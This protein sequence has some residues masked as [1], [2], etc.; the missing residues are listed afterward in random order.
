M[1]AVREFTSA[2][3]MKAHAASLKAKFFKPQP[4]KPQNSL[5][6][7][8]NAN[9]PKPLPKLIRFVEREPREWQTKTIDFN[10]HI[11]AYRLHQI[12]IEMEIVEGEVSFSLH[13]KSVTSI[14]DEVLNQFPGVTLSELRGVCRSLPIVKVRHLAMYEVWR[15]RPDLS[16]PAL[17]SWFGN[18]DHATVINAVRKICAEKGVDMP[19]RKPGVAG[20]PLPLKS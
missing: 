5:L 10:S 7:A 2:A 20:Q 13:R 4:V 15:Q 8:S 1:I 19:P 16:W 17:G 18:R 3:E 12:R 6:A 11:V 9:T 14:I